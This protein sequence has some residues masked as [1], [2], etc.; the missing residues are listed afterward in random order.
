MLV[1][2][3]WIGAIFVIVWY[4][5]VPAI[6]GMFGYVYVPGFGYINPENGMPEPPNDTNIGI[7]EEVTVGDMVLHDMMNESDVYDIGVIDFND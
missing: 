7:D 4:I 6:L 1:P 2:L 3:I 5:L